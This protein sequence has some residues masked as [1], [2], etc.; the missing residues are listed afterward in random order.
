MK[1]SLVRTAVIAAAG[2]LVAALISGCTLT[3]A[4]P[5]PL[6]PV[7]DNAGL[8]T[9]EPTTE[10]L[11]PT[12]TKAPTSDVFGTMTAQAPILALTATAQATQGGGAINLT[13]TPGLG[14]ITP[15]PIV[16]GTP[17]ATGNNGQ[18][19]STYTVQ[20][21]DNLFRI[22]LKFGLTTNQ[23]AAAN[24]ITNPAAIFVGQ[25]LKIPGCTGSSQ[26]NTSN[27]TPQP[28]SGETYT[29]LMGDN[30]FRIALKFGLDWQ[31]LAAFNNI[32]DP[33][34]LYVGQVLRIP[35]H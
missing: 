35:A 1:D 15:T 3:G 32:T 30:L 14:V 13:S 20:A 10:T 34:T 2:V 8:P 27:A 9:G 28:G 23:L 7:G 29:V 24:G 5:A 31:T 4:A 11:P 16:S 12:P 6:T 26:G 18:C 33:T 17:K 21:G 19:P 22:A 25:V